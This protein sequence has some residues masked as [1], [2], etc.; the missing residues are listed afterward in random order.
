VSGCRRT[1]QGESHSA[2]GWEIDGSAQLLP[3]VQSPFIR[4]MASR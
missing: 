2:S 4:A 3:R 1:L